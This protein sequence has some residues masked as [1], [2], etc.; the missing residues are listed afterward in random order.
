MRVDASAPVPARRSCTA[1]ISSQPFSAA[2][3]HVDSSSPTETSSVDVEAAATM[4]IAAGRVGTRG[5]DAP[6][7]K[8]RSAWGRVEATRVACV[9]VIHAR[10]R[11][12]RCVGPP[13]GLEWIGSR[14]AIGII[15]SANEVGTR[16]A[17]A[18]AN[19]ESKQGWAKRE[20]EVC[21]NAA[22]TLPAVFLHRH[23]LPQRRETS[24]RSRQDALLPR[25]SVVLL[26]LGSLFAA[27]AD[28][29]FL[30]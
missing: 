7:V 21:S 11:S 23:A 1:R 8:R 2:S 20:R 19:F 24:L 25:L 28:L 30:L 4:G 12:S 15:T 3:T 26:V 6:R 13:C 29:V 14:G 17:K 5:R 22:V 16:L 27:D 18:G 9:L 10:I